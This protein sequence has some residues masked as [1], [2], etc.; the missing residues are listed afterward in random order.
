M[1][2]FFRSVLAS[3]ITS[4]LSMKE[5]LGRQYTRER[6]ILAHLDPFL[7]LTLRILPRGRSSNGSQHVWA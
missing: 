3:T 2:S 6:R 7:L 1:N 4:Y 5:A